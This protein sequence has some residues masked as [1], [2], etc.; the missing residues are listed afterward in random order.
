MVKDEQAEVDRCKRELDKLLANNSEYARVLRAAIRELDSKRPDLNERVLAADRA[1]A[2]A[3]DNKKLKDLQARVERYQEE[4]RMLNEKIRNITHTLE[5]IR[6]GVRGVTNTIKDMVHEIKN[7]T[8][9]VTRVLIE[10]DAQELRRGGKLTFE[11]DLRVF[12]K[13]VTLTVYWS[14]M[15][16][17]QELFTEIAKRA[18]ANENATKFEIP[19]VAGDAG[20]EKPPTVSKAPAAGGGTGYFTG[21]KRTAV[22][23]RA[24]FNPRSRFSFGNMLVAPRPKGAKPL[25]STRLF[26]F[27]RRREPFT[28]G[29]GR[30]GRW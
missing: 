4:A 10:V 3:R 22:H 14:P 5:D 16:T 30:R 28:Q 1:I 9:S 17:A 8:I 20:N 26:E 6:K 21:E 19:A 12:G 18:I 15:Q 27:E 13:E 24:H 2:A 25:S 11:V 23:S 29:M 7:V